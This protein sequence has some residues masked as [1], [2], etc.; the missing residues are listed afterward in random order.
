[1]IQET[2]QYFFEWIVSCCS[3]GKH[4]ERTAE[5]MDL[6]FDIPDLDPRLYKLQSPLWIILELQRN[7]LWEIG[8][9]SHWLRRSIEKVKS[10]TQKPFSIDEADHS[11]GCSPSIYAA[12]FAVPSSLEI[13][14]EEGIK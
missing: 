14:V 10:I 2:G 13:L 3:K 9:Y 11:F 7:D 1:V 4:V 5:I 8:Q 12:S 6:L